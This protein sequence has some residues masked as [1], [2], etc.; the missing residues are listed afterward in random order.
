ME[1]SF[2]KEKYEYE[3]EQEKIKWIK[4]AKEEQ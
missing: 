1:E 4:W 3:Y 2:T